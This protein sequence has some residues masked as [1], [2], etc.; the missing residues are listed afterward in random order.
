[1]VSPLVAPTIVTAGGS[2][3]ICVV[4]CVV[5]CCVAC[6]VCGL[7]LLVMR[8][9]ETKLSHV[10]GLPMASK[11]FHVTVAVEGSAHGIPDMLL[12]DCSAKAVGA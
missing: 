7:A 1:M 9:L 10:M 11:P 2:I 4:F 5:F 3:Q 12:G 8:L 6:V